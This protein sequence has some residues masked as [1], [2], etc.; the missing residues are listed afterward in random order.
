M[1]RFFSSTY[2]PVI[3]LVLL[4]E[5]PTHCLGGRHDPA[6]VATRFAVERVA[7]CVVQLRPLGAEPDQQ[8]RR[9]G[10]VSS[11]LLLP[12]AE[13][14]VLTA[15][16]GF[17]PRP[18][19]V[20]VGFQDRSRGGAET[21][22]TD[23]VLG[24]TLLR[25]E[26]SA[27]RESAN[28]RFATEVPNVGQTVL[29]LGRARDA[30]SVNLSRGVVSAVGRLGVGAIQVDASVSRTN[31]GGPLV[32]LDGAVL[33]LLS[34][35]P[36]IGLAAPSVEFEDAGIGFAIPLELALHSVEKLKQGK[37]LRRG[38]F[39]L[40]LDADHP[41]R[42]TPR[43]AEVAANS[44]LKQGDVVLSIDGV[45]TASLTGALAV[46]QR[47]HAGGSVLFGVE[48]DGSSLEV[49]VELSDSEFQADSA[50]RPKVKK[51]PRP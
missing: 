2:L 20:V 15:S 28:L 10:I 44:P 18:Q 14:W 17:S 27:R 48:R 50:R 4:G 7:P 6:A 35:L 40:K 5:T 13:G 29:A 8:G 9:G 16:Y 3:V 12:G 33:G 51:A 43:V 34:P 1:I 11:G 22:A 24:I 37:D 45:P 46:Q 39:P 47:Q 23:E 30:G 41:Y 21:I 26:P 31:Y 38:W 25:L 42:G 19:A 36:T 49:R 32:A